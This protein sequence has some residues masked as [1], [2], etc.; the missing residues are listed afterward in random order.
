MLHDPTLVGPYNQS[1]SQ[2]IEEGRRTSMM[3]TS[4]TLAVVMSLP[5]IDPLYN[6]IPSD[7]LKIAF[8][9]IALHFELVY[10]KSN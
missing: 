7:I 4:N 9:K 3:S 8:F 2:L 6:L 10:L 1:S 5:D